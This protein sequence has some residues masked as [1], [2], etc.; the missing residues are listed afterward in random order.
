MVISANIKEIVSEFI[1]NNAFKK[2]IKKE[3]KK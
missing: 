1:R 3:E 2:R